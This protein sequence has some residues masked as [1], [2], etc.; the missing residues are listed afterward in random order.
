MGNEINGGQKFTY[1]CVWDQQLVKELGG[2]S[3]LLTIECM[4]LKEGADTSYGADLID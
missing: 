4:A 2:S 3:L 1:P